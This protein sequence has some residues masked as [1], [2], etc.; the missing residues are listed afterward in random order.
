MLVLASAHPMVAGTVAQSVALAVPLAI[1]LPRLRR[2]LH[3][4]TAWI[5]RHDLHDLAARIHADRAWWAEVSGQ[6][7][8]AAA[9]LP[10]GF[11]DLVR[12]AAESERP[13]LLVEPPSALPQPRRNVDVLSFIL[14][15]AVRAGQVAVLMRH[16]RTPFLIGDLEDALR[17]GHAYRYAAARPRAEG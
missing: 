14:L 8:S 10:S 13:D 9:L 1:D 2:P 17:W 15:P 6:V 7:T 12:R 4:W 16:R 3:T 11:A 5:G